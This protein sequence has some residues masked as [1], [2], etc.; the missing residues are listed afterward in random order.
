[1][2]LDQRRDVVNTLHDSV[3]AITQKIIDLH[4]LRDQLAAVAIEENLRLQK[5]LKIEIR[6]RLKKPARRRKK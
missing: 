1:M 4:I 2:T 6:R 5:E 3:V